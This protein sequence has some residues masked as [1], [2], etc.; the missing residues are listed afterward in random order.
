[1]KSYIRRTIDQLEALGFDR[2]DNPT[3]RALRIRIYRHPYDPE[4][5][6]KIWEG[7]S[8]AWCITQARRAHEIA[9]LG[10]HGPKMPTS[11]KERTNTLRAAEK[12]RRAANK[13]DYLQRAEHAEKRDNNEARR[14]QLISV[15]M[16]L[17]GAGRPRCF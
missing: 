12:R 10:T 17:M 1:M 7:A 9:G 8:E 11:I 2:D 16:N 4:Q 15:S 13:A 5:E 3:H 6:L 14:Q